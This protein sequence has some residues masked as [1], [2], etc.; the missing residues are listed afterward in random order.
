MDSTRKTAFVVGVLFIITFVTSIPAA[1][2]LYS[3][4]LDDVNYILGA[5]ADNRIALGAFLE[6]ILIV[7]N[8]GTAVVLFPI[9]KR[10]N[11]ALSLGYV[12]ARLV[13]CSFIAVG[14]LSLLAVVSLR[15][16][17]A[18][19]AGQT[20]SRSIGRRG[21]ARI[22]LARDGT[23]AESRDQVSRWGESRPYRIRIPLLT[24]RD[25]S[26]IPHQRSRTGVQ[27]ER[28]SV[29]GDQF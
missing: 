16:D 19:A 29:P 24:R 10:Q 12:T 20:R 22:A 21:N 1:L 17:L 15:Q 3:P 2:A 28:V 26:S 8:I 6:M 11:E 18:G 7:A 14:L 4:V 25:D 13:E 5:G 27:C 9:V 23:P